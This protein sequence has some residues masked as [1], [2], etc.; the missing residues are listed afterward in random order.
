VVADGQLIAFISAGDIYVIS[1]DG[2]GLQRL[3]DNPAEDGYPAWLPA[4][5][6]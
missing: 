5:R 4:S 3:T 1:V 6:K 2:R